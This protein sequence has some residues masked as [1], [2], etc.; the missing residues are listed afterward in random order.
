MAF[1]TLSVNP[2]FP[3]KEGRYLNSVK[4]KTEGG[5]VLARARNERILR[6]F[7]LS[8]SLL[9]TA[10]H[11]LLEAHIASVQD[12]TAFDWTH[13]ISSVTYNVRFKTVPDF[14]YALFNRWNISFTLD[15]I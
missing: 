14:D 9:P 8:Y 7:T 5:Y 2:N 15:Q 6:F 4:T 11:D 13:P 1:P 3:I 12:I 10:D